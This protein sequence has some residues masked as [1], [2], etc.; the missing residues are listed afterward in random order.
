MSNNIDLSIEALDPI[1][2]DQFYRGMLTLIRRIPSDKRIVSIFVLPNYE[3]VTWM[4]SQWIK[5]HLIDEIMQEHKLLVFPLEG[6]LAKEKKLYPIFE[7]NKVVLFSGVMH[8][9]TYLVVGQNNDILIWDAWAKRIKLAANGIYHAR[10]SCLSGKELSPILAKEGSPADKA[11]KD[12]F[13][14]LVKNPTYPIEDPLITLFFEPWKNYI[15]SLLKG[16]SPNK[17]LKIET[18]AWKKRIDKITSPLI[19]GNLQHDLRALVIYGQKLNK[20]LKLPEVMPIDIEVTYDIEKRNGKY[21]ILLTAYIT[22]KNNPISGGFTRLRLSKE[23]AYKY[24]FNK[25]KQGTSQFIITSTKKFADELRL[26][27]YGFVDDHGNIFPSYEIVF[28][29]DWSNSHPSPPPV[30]PHGNKRDAVIIFNPPE[31]HDNIRTTRLIQNMQLQD[32]DGNPIDGN[33]IV[34]WCNHTRVVNIEN[35]KGTF[36]TILAKPILG[37]NIVKVH[38]QYNGSSKYNEVNE[39]ETYTVKGWINEDNISIVLIFLGFILAML[40]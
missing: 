13:T 5:Y 28:K 16:N 32:K 33:I 38:Y 27:F 14:F 35:G 10:L 34:R 19:K 31:Y 20:S 22:S 21:H 6:D 4:G 26:E 12:T 17:S 40:F 15:M 3:Q 37:N 24:K 9:T 8:G 18:D 11:Y 36:S 30:P 25:I 23:D 7:T 1:D 39:T 2:R 29:I